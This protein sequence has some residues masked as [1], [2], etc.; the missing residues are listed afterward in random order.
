MVRLLMLPAC[1]PTERWSPDANFSFDGVFIVPRAT[2]AHRHYGPMAQDF[3]AAFGQDGVGSIGSETAINSSDLSGV[4]M[5][6]VQALE[7][8]TAGLE[9]ENA[10]LKARLEA[11]EGSRN[12]GS[13]RASARKSPNRKARIAPIASAA[14]R[15][16]P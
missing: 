16:Q 12:R 11:S 14:A 4:L 6:A 10:E 1:F 13:P 8:R 9:N 3:F 2:S 7:K 5:L 15:P